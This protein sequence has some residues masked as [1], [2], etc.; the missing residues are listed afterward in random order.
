[1]T[2]RPSIVNGHGSGTE[3]ATASATGEETA[4]GSRNSR[5]AQIVK[6]VRGPDR[7]ADDMG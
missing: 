4:S 5:L 2:P 7:G 3:E 6:S 1:M